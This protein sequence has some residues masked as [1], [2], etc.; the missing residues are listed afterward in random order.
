MSTKL[1]LYPAWIRIWHL[2]NALL[3][4]ALIITGISMQYS[5]P[6]NPLVTFRV[7]VKIHNYSGIILSFNYLVFAAGNLLTKNGRFYRLYLKGLFQRLMKQAMYY[8]VGIFK[9]EKAPFPVNE[10]RKFN[11]LQLV[12][13]W[14]V[15][16][17]AVPLV[18]LSGWVMLYPELVLPHFPGLNGVLVTD[19]VHIFCGFIISIFMLVH[20]YFCT[21]GHTAWSNFRSMINGWHEVHE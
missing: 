4:L 15:M 1:Y 3:C 21:I 19:M 7:A 14:V 8:S 12:A 6:S 20:I 11:P 18:I 2:I 5:E 17:I 9:N 16:L 13:Y 10:S